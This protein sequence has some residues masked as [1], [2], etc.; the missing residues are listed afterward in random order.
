MQEYE[1]L[2]GQVRCVV[3]LYPQVT[4]DQPPKDVGYAAFPYVVEDGGQSRRAVGDASS[5]ALQFVGD[6]E[7]SAIAA[8]VAY[9][10]DRF[11]VAGEVA[12]S[13]A[14][15]ARSEKLPPLR[16][17]RFGPAAGQE[18]TSEDVALLANIERLLDVIGSDVR[19]YVNDSRIHAGLM[20]D[21]GRYRRVCAAMDM[22]QDTAQA[23]RAYVRHPRTSGDKG[24]A[25]LVVFG[26]LQALYVQQDA[27]YWLLLGLGYPA[28][29]QQFKSPGK[30]VSR[31]ADLNLVRELRN[32][33][34]GHP[35]NKDQGPNKG[36]FFITQ[37]TLSVNGFQL[38]AIKDDDSREFVPVSVRALVGKQLETLLGTFQRAIEEAENAERAHRAQFSE[39]RLEAIFAQLDYPLEKLGAATSD[40]EPRQLGMYGVDAVRTAMASF[41]ERLSARGEPFDAGLEL[42]YQRLET[43]LVPLADFCSE[44]RGMPLQMADVLSEF[45][46]DKVDDLR[47]Y[48]R[49]IDEDYSSTNVDASLIDASASATSPRSS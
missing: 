8:T 36:S 49:T 25:Y 13:E 47:E 5:N 24:T 38:L 37:M 10:E 39:E 48:A 23:L 15:T 19:G 30:W 9:L 45:V 29:V 1:L 16:D 2:C 20:A 31:N 28:D 44:T 35:V 22:I 32:S 42:L 27:S 34:I 18:A 43:A 14:S 21:A 17:E 46:A 6:T 26:A 4:D 3:I 11:G 41:R 7:D 40:D 12:K 33:S